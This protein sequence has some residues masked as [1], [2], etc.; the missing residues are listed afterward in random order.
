MPTFRSASA[1]ACPVRSGPEITTTTVRAGGTANTTCR[2]P[3]G[4]TAITMAFGGPPFTSTATS[5]LPIAT[6]GGAGTTATTTVTGTTT[7]SP[8]TMTGIMTADGIT[9]RLV[10]IAAGGTITI[11][12]D[13]IAATM[14]GAAVKTAPSI[15]EGMADGIAAA[16]V[17]GADTNMATATIIT[18]AD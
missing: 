11:T 8:S 5:S 10:G 13:G 15:A 12:A 2:R 9:A 6:I 7:I 18:A 3:I 14:A 4:A 17:V 1:L 16:M